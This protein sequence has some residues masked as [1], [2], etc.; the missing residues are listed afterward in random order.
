MFNDKLDNK[1]AEAVKE[2]NLSAD[3]KKFDEGID[4]KLNLDKLNISGGQR[5][6]IV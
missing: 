5:Q 1:V 3:L 2:V 6:K 4:K